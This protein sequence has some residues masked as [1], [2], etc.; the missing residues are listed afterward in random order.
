M[1]K[2]LHNKFDDFKDFWNP[3]IFRVESH[4]KTLRQSLQEKS[5]IPRRFITSHC[6]IFKL[7]SNNFLNDQLGDFQF[8]YKMTI[9]K[10]H[11]SQYSGNKI[12]GSQK[13][14]T[15]ESASRWA[16]GHGILNFFIRPCLRR[17]IANDQRWSFVI[18]KNVCILL[19]YTNCSVL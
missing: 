2:N 11:E 14:G 13:W 5:H 15:L 7:L 6:F 1:P 16:N 3:N 12:T 8:S 10:I 4:F 18:A 19:V 9:L 17:V